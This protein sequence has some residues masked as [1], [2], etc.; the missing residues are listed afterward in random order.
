MRMILPLAIALALSAGTA[1]AQDLKR[2]AAIGQGI[3]CDTSD[4]AVRFVTLL[5]DGATADRAVQT[6]NTE[7]KDERAC[8]EA[9][10]AFTMDEDVGSQHMGGKPVS[11]AKITVLAI[12]HDGAHWAPISPKVQYTVLPAKGEEI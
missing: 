6:I 9:V 10:I 8:G 2:D 4:Q 12:S 1:S 7:A 3:I 5:N 11:I